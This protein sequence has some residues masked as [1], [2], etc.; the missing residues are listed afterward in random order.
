M[1]AAMNGQQCGSSRL[2]QS[3]AQVREDGEVRD[4]IAGHHGAG[5]P[6]VG[7]DLAQRAQAR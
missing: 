7:L 5:P 3:L 1:H 4:A 6:P 2:V